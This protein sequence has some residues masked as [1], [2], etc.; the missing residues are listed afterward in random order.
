MCGVDLPTMKQLLADQRRDLINDM[1]KQIVS[2]VA[3]QLAPHVARLDQLQD[4]QILLKKQLSAIYSQLRPS[5]CPAPAP[6]RDTACELPT[7]DPWPIPLNLTPSSHESQTM[8]CLETTQAQL[9]R[10]QAPPEGRDDPLFE[11]EIE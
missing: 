5:L 6:S 10:K 4:D 8:P 11:L 1:K 3:T 7:A 9:V 2:E